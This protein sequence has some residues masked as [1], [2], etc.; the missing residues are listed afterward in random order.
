MTL[1]VEINRR[2]LM[3]AAGVGMTSVSGFSQTT[4]GQNSS[5]GDKIWSFQTDG[6]VSSSPT[7]IDGT[8]FIV[9]NDKYLYALDASTG[10]QKWKS[11]LWTTDYVTFSS[12]PN[13]VSNTVF[14]TSPDG[15]LHAIDSTTGEQQWVSSIGGRWSPTVIDDTVFVGNQAINASTGDQLW[16]FDTGSIYPEVSPV[17]VDGKVFIGDNAGIFYAIDSSTGEEL[18]R[19]NTG[20]R[21]ESSPAVSDN[22]VVIGRDSY[23]YGLDKTNGEQLWSG[24]T[25]TGFYSPPTV[26]DNGGDNDSMVFL[27]GAEQLSRFDLDSGE[28][29][30]GTHLQA[31]TESSPTVCNGLIFLGAGTDLIARD[32][33]RRR[34]IWKFSTSGFIESSPTVVDG[35]VYIGSNDGNLYAVEAGVEGSS[36]GSRVKLGTLG[37]HGTF[38]GRSQTSEDPTNPAPSASFDFSPSS[39]KVDEEITFDGS[40]SSDDTG[41]VTYEWDFNNDDSFESSGEKTTTTFESAG[42]NTITLRVTDDQGRSDS[43]SQTISISNTSSPPTASFEISPS[44]PEVGEEITLDA[45]G[46][47]DDN[48][49]AT[50]AWDINDNGT[51]DFT[52]QTTTVS[53]DSTG[54]NTITLRVKDKQGKSDT[55]SQTISVNNT[56]SAPT[57]SFDLSPTEPE[58]GEDVNFDASSSSDDNSIATY[59]WDLNDDGSYDVAGQSPTNTFGSAG[60]YTVTLRVTDNQGK[61]DS[62]SKTISVINGNSPPKASFYTSPGAPLVDEEVTLDASGSSGDNGIAT[63]EWDLNDNGTFSTTGQTTTVSFDSTGEYTIT[64]RVTDT[65]GATSTS[66]Q[67]LSVSTDEFQ[68]YKEIHLETAQRV[69]EAT[70]SDMGAENEARTAN[71]EYTAAVENGEINK[72]TAIEAIRRFISGCNVTLSVAEV[73][74]PYSD[75]SFEVDLTQSMAS[76][77]IQTVL[78]LYSG[79]KAMS[80]AASSS[81]SDSGSVDSSTNS[82]SI[83]NSTKSIIFDTVSETAQDQAKEGINTLI[84]Y[85][86]GESSNIAGT[87]EIESNKIVENLFNNTFSTAA[88][89]NEAIQDAKSRIA[90]S[91]SIGLQTKIEQG[92][93]LGMPEIP[94]LKGTIFED[95]PVTLDGGLTLM[96]QALSANNVRSNGLNGS[97]DGARS[98]AVEQEQDINIQSRD[99]QTDIE[100][101]KKLSA[102]TGIAS[103]LIDLIKSPSFYDVATALLGILNSIVGS[104]PDALATGAGIGG[105]IEI[106][107]RH[108]IG[109]LGVIRGDTI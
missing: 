80:K 90:E 30:Y 87:I 94:Q 99:S 59:E 7:V 93:S 83:S 84:K 105:L 81:V 101:F 67:T 8:V 77:T 76:P 70:I 27:A 38:I 36:E 64:L 104:I 57:A 89:V 44:N 2:N 4:E 52:G 19:F 63:Y 109:L 58:V 103:A 75:S 73:I 3:I 15:K 5:G 100:N 108:H 98:A 78:D 43:T 39:P 68:Q 34:T 54:E 51:F 91:A 107:I 72:Q 16:K 41:I 37:H 9:S 35:T 95:S 49:I 48:G 40:E 47:S 28:S 61:S 26:K 11:K 74:G 18:W 45:S 10:E 62:V 71:K 53:F 92:N 60:D 55:T 32:I 79:I 65:E 20:G 69:D 29:P 85:M 6:A 12:S 97:L 88:D 82:A 25:G 66:E 22:Y 13:V 50:F 31:D 33:N 56:N 106:N 96:Y 86:L 21:I 46:S 1:P 17:V 23:I 102:D 24:R 42:E 14:V